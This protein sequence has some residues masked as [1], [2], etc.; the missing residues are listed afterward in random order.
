M[1]I[2]FATITT[3]IIVCIFV[4]VV[5]VVCVFHFKQIQ[6]IKTGISFWIGTDSWSEGVNRCAGQAV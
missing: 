2:K 5:G 4:I 6:F 3:N 1:F